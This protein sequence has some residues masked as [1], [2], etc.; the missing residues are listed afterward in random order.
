MK[1]NKLIATVTLAI[2]GISGLALA[3][4]SA[5]ASSVPVVYHGIGKV[6]SELDVVCVS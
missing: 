2:A 5:S 4:G 6:V 1:L 3:V